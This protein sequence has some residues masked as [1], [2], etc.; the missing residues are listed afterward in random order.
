MTI[1]LSNAKAEE[2]FFD[3]LCNGLGQLGM[4]GLLLDV[5]VNHY[6]D[7][8]SQLE[9]IFRSICFE[10]VLIK[11]LKLGYPLSFKDDECDG[12]YDAHVTLDSIHE[13]VPTAP[14]YL[15]D[16]MLTGEDDACTA[17]GILQWVMYN[18]IIFG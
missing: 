2:I 14:S 17:D 7:A 18:E 12:E 6:R 4:Y 3:A 13:R 1:K 16:A 9:T 5:N 10:D 11:M 15:L 8:S